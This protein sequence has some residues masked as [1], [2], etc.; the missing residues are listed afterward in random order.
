MEGCRISH[1]RSAG[2]EVDCSPFRKECQPIPHLFPDQDEP[3]PRVGFIVTNLPMEP[4]WVV[5]FYNQRGTAG[6]H[7][8]EGKYAFRWTRLSCWKFRDNEVLLQMHA[9]AYNLATFLRFIELPEAMA[10]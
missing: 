1:G 4:D 3:F 8:K 2:R 6:Q 10:D 7:I 9:L 5:R